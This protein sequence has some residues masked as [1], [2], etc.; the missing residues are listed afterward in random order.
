MYKYAITN[1]FATELT[2]REQKFEVRFVE[3]T[4]KE[5]LLISYRGDNIPVTDFQFFFEETGCNVALRVFD[6]VE[7]V[8]PEKFEAIRSAINASNTEYRFMCFYLD[9][10][11]NSISGKIDFI[12][13][14]NCSTKDV[15]SE[16][17]HHAVSISDDC[18]PNF[19]KAIWS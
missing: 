9:E 11:D 19:M 5:V 18:Y 12:L 4:K 6:L 15:L 16:Y 2:S 17:L 7:K 8:P 13:P 10:E 14:E 3:N 1:E